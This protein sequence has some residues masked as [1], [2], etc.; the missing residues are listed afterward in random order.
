MAWFSEVLLPRT[1]VGVINSGGAPLT[2]GELLRYLGIRLLMSTCM[3]WSTDQF[4]GNY[5]NIPRDQE[6]DPCP[7]NFRDYMSRRRFIALTWYLNFTNVERPAF[8]DKIWQVRQMIKAWNDHMAAIFLAA[9]VICLDESMSIWHN[10]WTCPGWIFCP[11]KPHPFGN[12]YHTACCGLGNIMISIELVEGKDAPPQIRKQFEQYGKTAGL[13]LRMLQSY[14][15]TARYIVLDSGFCVL[16]AIIELRKNGLFGFALIKKR[17]Y[18]P[19][20]VPGDA[21][22]SFFDEDGVNVGDNHAISGTMDGVPYNLWGMKEPDYVMRMMATGEPMSALESCKETVRKWMENGVEVVRRFR[23]ACPFDWHFRY[24]HA[25]DDH[26]NLRHGLPSIEDSW[27]THRWEVRVFTFILAITEVNAFLALRYFTFANGSI[28]GCP[29][30]LVFRRRLAWQLIR[31]SWIVAEE[32]AAGDVAIGSVHRLLTAP[33]K[34]KKYQNRQWVCTAAR[35]YQ[36][37]KC[38]HGCGRKIRTYCACT[39]G[40]WVCYQCYPEHVATVDSED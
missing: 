19:A 20:G 33:K 13:L 26:N 18:W 39:P 6:D 31:N 16:K 32:E 2:F 17:R 15:H 1:S 9:W 36:Q 28:P 38:T 8:V 35:D 22:Q 7:Y 37:Y 21:M 12:K 3:G 10:K 5:D 4:W 25:V 30:L 27:T 23:Y 34:A 24:R 29:S 14:F 40:R 11:R